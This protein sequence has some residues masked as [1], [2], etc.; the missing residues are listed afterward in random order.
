MRPS[1]SFGLNVLSSMAASCGRTGASSTGPAPI[2]EGGRPAPSRR[3]IHQNGLP[4]AAR[5][6]DSRDFFPDGAFQNCGEV[7]I[8][9]FAD[10]GLHSTEQFIAMR[11]HP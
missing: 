11:I 1:T 6:Y 8:H 4:A 5:L 2:T 10:E 7:L 3:P 9:P